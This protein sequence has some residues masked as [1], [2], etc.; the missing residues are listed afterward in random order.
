MRLHKIGSFRT[1][2]GVGVCDVE[3]AGR[4]SGGADLRVQVR[5]LCHRFSSLSRGG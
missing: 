1:R 4:G 5:G 3:G 2:G